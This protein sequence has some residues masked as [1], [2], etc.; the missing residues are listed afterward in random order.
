M[1][2]LIFLFRALLILFQA[3]ELPHSRRSE[4]IN[5]PLCNLLYVFC[6]IVCFVKTLWHVRLHLKCMFVDHLF[7]LTCWELQQE[8][9]VDHIGFNIMFA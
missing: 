1:F 7:G 6:L 9:W 5:F 4:G 3:S 2:E 8:K